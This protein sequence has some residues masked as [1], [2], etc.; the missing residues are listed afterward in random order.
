[1]HMPQVRNLHLVFQFLLQITI[2]NFTYCLV[3]YYLPSGFHPQPLPHENSKSSKSFYLTL[4]STMQRLREECERDSGPK[5]VVSV[6]AQVGGVIAASDS[7]EIPLNEQVK[8]LHE[9]CW[10]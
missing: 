5:K 10:N 2:I 9:V 4:P 7:C 3:V 6:S 8:G 1:M